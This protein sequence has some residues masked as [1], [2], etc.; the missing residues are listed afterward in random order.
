MKILFGEL[1]TINLRHGLISCFHRHG[2]RLYVTSIESSFG[3][4][5]GG[6]MLK[7]KFFSEGKDWPRSQLEVTVKYF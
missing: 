4:D 3:V 1:C 2:F 7:L 6:L 5:I